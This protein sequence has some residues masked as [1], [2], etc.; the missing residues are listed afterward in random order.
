MSTVLDFFEDARSLRDRAQ[1][2]FDEFQQLIGRSAN[3]PLWEVKEYPDGDGGTFTYALHLNHDILTKVKPVAA[4]AA[5][6]LVHSL[7]QLV[8]AAARLHGRGRHRNLYFPWI[9]DEIAF[10]RQLRALE[11][12]IGTGAVTA[13]REVRNRHKA[14]LPHIHAVKTVS[15]SGKH[16]ALTPSTSSAAAVA[17]N[18]PGQPQ[19]I[20]DIPPAAF[21][22][23]EAYDFAVGVQRMQGVPFMVLLQFAFE[24][25]G[26]GVPASPDD[27]FSWAFRYVKDMIDAVDAVQN[28]RDP[29]PFA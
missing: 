7:D 18:L 10:E 23:S 27:I 1:R 5:N 3:P 25:L 6:N 28:W 24:G 14:A 13:I 16:W 2:H 12:L 11:Q 21:E 15:N 29:D 20:W 4:D 22:G 9:L 8:G 26:E 19:K 17:V